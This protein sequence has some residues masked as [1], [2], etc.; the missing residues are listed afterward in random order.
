MSAPPL[1]RDRLLWR[2]RGSH[3][4]WWRHGRGNGTG[5]EHEDHQPAS[6]ER[7]N[8]HSHGKP[9]AAALP[10]CRAGHGSRI[11]ARRL[12][13][14]GIRPP[15]KPRAGDGGRRVR[16]APGILAHAKAAHTQGIP[17]AGLGQV[18]L[19][20]PEFQTPS[21]SPCHTLPSVPPALG[22]ISWSPSARGGILAPEWCEL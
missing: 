19:E 4:R 14:A 16:P 7:Q 10:L 17:H 5:R 18:H 8:E 9:G 2:Y 1:R 22:F 3:R 6:D 21:E 20:R 13:L 15:V 11:A 12:S